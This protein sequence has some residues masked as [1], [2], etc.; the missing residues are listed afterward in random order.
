MAFYITTI[1]LLFILFEKITFSFFGKK[2]VLIVLG[3]YIV[4]RAVVS[5]KVVLTLP[6]SI[7]QIIFNPYISYLFS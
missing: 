3:F 5:S 6:T 7:V 1:I 4:V 2:N